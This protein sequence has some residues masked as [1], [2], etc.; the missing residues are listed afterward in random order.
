[1]RLQILLISLLCF[2]FAATAEDYAS[3]PNDRELSERCWISLEGNNTIQMPLVSFAGPGANWTYPFTFFPVYA[4]NQTISGSV[5]CRA[6]MTGREVR[7]CI[8]DF[9]MERLLSALTAQ[10][11]ETVAADGDLPI[12]L[13]DT[14]DA[15]FAI[16]GVPSGLYTITVADTLNSTIIAATPVLVAEGEIATNFPSEVE[17]GDILQLGIETPQKWGN[18]SKFYGAIMISSQDYATAGLSLTTNGTEESLLSTIAVGNS[19]MQI[20]GLPRVST[21]LLMNLSAILPQNSTV[22]MQPSTEPEVELYLLTDSALAKGEY[23]L[24]SAVYSPKKGLMGMRQG[25][26]EVI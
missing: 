23:I 13:N 3:V 26:V 8:S 20:Q 17:A 12:R 19:S 5:L 9:S 14:G 2:C 6:E 16:Q 7:V 21:D 18:E 1:M 11:N 4:E 22:A 10:D 24:T 25:T 15:R